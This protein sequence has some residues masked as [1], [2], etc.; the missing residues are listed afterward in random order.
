MAGPVPGLSGRG[1]RCLRG[2]G[3][4]AVCGVLTLVL[5]ACV[6][7]AR[8]DSDYRADIATT[9]KMAV[10]FIA[11]AELTVGAVVEG[12]AA[13]PY[14]A[15]RLTEDENGLNSVITSFASV[16][17]PSAELDEVRGDVLALLN[18]SSSVVGELRIAAFRDRHGQLA[19]IADPLPELADELAR[20]EHVPAS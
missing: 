20:Y 5:A 15:R 3:I 9:A 14:V 13:S 11:S 8:T 19:E 12:K 6:G 4:T 7:P 2:G 16:Q 10:S 17:P 1:A 18:R